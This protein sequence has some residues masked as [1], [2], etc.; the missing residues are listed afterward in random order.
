MRIRYEYRFDLEPPHPEAGLRTQFFTDFDDVCELQDLANHPHGERRAW[1]RML[2]QK[3]RYTGKT[4]LT[5]SD[6]NCAYGQ[7]VLCVACPNGATVTVIEPNNMAS[8]IILIIQVQFIFF[9]LVNTDGVE[10]FI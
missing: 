9:F 1:A 4:T 5:D 8:D 10:L 2:L 7:I 3:Y 6:F